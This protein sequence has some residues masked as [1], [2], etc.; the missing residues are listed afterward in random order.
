MVGVFELKQLNNNFIF[1]SLFFCAAALLIVLSLRKTIGSRNIKLL[2]LFNV[3][4]LIYFAAG[5]QITSTL[6][7]FIHSK[8]N[9]HEI[10][11]I[12][13]ASAYAAFY[14][15]AV[16]V[17][18][19]IITSLKSLQASPT[20]RLW[21]SL[22]ITIMSLCC[23]T[24]ATLGFCI[25]LL[26]LVGIFLM[27]LAESILVPVGYSLLAD[28]TPKEYMNIMMGIRVL[29]IGIGGYLS[30]FMASTASQAHKAHPLFTQPYLD[31]FLYITTTL[32]V[33]LLVG[34]IIDKRFGL[35]KQLR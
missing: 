16:I 11:S 7:V 23:F 26:V 10:T 9:L 27:G 15:L 19:P 25:V 6:L 33:F 4:S 31:E 34:F 24:V 28:N 13:P 1:S 29:F 5:F 35:I 18:I 17:I 3:F 2:L 20:T 12:L 32:A 30:G 22:S 8:I 14:P 21:L